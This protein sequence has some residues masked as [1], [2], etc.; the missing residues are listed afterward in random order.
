MLSSNAV[1]ISTNR[2]LLIPEPGIQWMSTKPIPLKLSVRKKPGAWAPD[3][4]RHSSSTGPAPSHVPAAYMPPILDD[5][6]KSQAN[7]PAKLARQLPPMIRYARELAYN[8]RSKPSGLPVPGRG[9]T[10]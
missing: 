3:I 1:D 6:Q 8:P 5:A 2:T 4:S 10:S 7:C 9:S